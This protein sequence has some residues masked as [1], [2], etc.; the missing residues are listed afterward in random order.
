MVSVIIPS[1]NRNDWL[2]E[3]LPSYLAE[4]VIDE[5]IIIDDASE[6]PYN[7]PDSKIKI[8][9][10][11]IQ[12]GAPY[13]RNLGVLNSKNKHIMFG[14]DDVFMSPDYCNSLFSRMNESPSTLVASGQIYFLDSKERV[15]DALKRIKNMKCTK[16]LFDYHLH[17]GVK[18]DVRPCQLINKIPYTHAIFMS[19][20]EILL[21]HKFE[22]E[23]SK[24]GGF[25]EESSAQLDIYNSKKTEAILYGDLSCFHVSRLDVTK[26][27][28]RAARLKRFVNINLN[29]FTFFKK[30]SYS[31]KFGYF[32]SCFSFFL[33]SIY[34]LFIRPLKHLPKI[35]RIKE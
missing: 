34:S 30:R 35:M 29:T 20:K 24:N 14:E 8:I 11:N 25:R 13:C 7:F 5:I 12:K 27:G 33:Y 2:Q 22:E 1:R 18:T 6:K 19:T 4:K 32:I 26:G 28:Q 17:Y 10:N 31:S 21:N 15:V 16:L 9:R 23:F 3:V